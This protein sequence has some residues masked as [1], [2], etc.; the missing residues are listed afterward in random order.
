MSLAEPPSAVADPSTLERLGAAV[1]AA[2][3]AA[4][5]VVVL[6]TIVLGLGILVLAYWAGSGAGV[7]RGVVAATSA[8]AMHLAFA[9]FILF[10]ATI[11][12]AASGVQKF[13]VA[14][15]VFAAAARRAEAANPRLRER[16]DFGELTRAIA[17]ALDSLVDEPVPLPDGAKPGRIR[18]ATGLVRRVSRWLVRRIGR[19]IVHELELVPHPDG[20]VAYA[21]VDEWMGTRLDKYAC[22]TIRIPAQRWLGALLLL[23]FVGTA[24]LVVSARTVPPIW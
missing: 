15:S 2:L 11:L 3:G 1:Y 19:A 12:A 23:Q 21:T 4:A 6:H 9:P 7:I 14:R 18:R 16:N 24:G 5:K 17:A 8:I 20:H 13:G 10:W 22:D